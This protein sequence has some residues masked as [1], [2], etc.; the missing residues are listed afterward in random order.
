MHSLEKGVIGQQLKLKNSHAC[1][2][3]SLHCGLVV[4]C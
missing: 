3:R 4:D 2:L 1:M